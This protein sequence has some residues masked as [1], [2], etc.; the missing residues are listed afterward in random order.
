MGNKASKSKESRSTF[1]FSYGQ[2]YYLFFSQNGKDRDL[3]FLSIPYFMGYMGLFFSHWSL[4]FNPKEE[5]IATPVWVKLPHLPLRFWEERTLG[6][7][8]DKLGQYIDQAK[9]KGHMYSCVRICMEVDLE[10]GLFKALK[11]N[12]N[13]WSHQ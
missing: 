3:I 4:E 13:S 11:I 9:P 10:K 8:A 6:F 2:I 12:T 5:I 7:I 1:S